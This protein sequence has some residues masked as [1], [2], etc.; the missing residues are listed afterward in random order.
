MIVSKRF[1]GDK[2]D[3]QWAQHDEYNKAI[4]IIFAGCRKHY[5]AQFENDP[6]NEVVPAL[7]NL[8]SFD[9]RVLQDFHDHMAAYWRKQYLH[10]NKPI[11]ESVKEWLSWLEKEV[12]NLRAKSRVYVG[13]CF[14]ALD[15]YDNSHAARVAGFLQTYT[16]K[17]YPLKWQHYL[18]RASLEDTL[19]IVYALSFLI[20]AAISL[21]SGIA[22]YKEMPSM[23]IILGLLFGIGYIFANHQKLHDLC[24]KNVFVFAIRILLIFLGAFGIALLIT[25][26]TNFQSG[27][28][29]N[30]IAEIAIFMA[31]ITSLHLFKQLCFKG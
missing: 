9:H 11:Q 4:G 15:R 7:K 28:I 1:E 17:M 2:T 8:H 21:Y 20:F 12:H 27:L 30:H 18:Q 26:L 16:Q 19:N 5:L 22:F 13:I 6:E 29:F 23:A 24:M 31:C 14:L 25:G 10:P 3:F